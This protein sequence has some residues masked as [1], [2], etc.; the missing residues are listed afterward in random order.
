MS[1]GAISS[2]LDMSKAL[3]KVPGLPSLWRTEKNGSA[4]NVK[5]VTEMADPTAAASAIVQALG[6]PYFLLP[7]KEPSKLASASDWKV[8]LWQW[9]S[10]SHCLGQ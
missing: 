2:N 10:R 8:Q 7:S 1:V 6:E 9:L 3:P 5:A 4:G